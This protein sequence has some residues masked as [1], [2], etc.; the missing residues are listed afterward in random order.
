[1]TE[2]SIQSWRPPSKLTMHI[3]ESS[4]N[5]EVLR[6][7]RKRLVNIVDVL[8]GGVAKSVDVLDVFRKVTSLPLA[9]CRGC[10]CQHPRC[11]HHPLHHR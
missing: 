8:R 11:L 6:D 10:C 4:S 9:G 2:V 5:G 7:F 3:A 1:L